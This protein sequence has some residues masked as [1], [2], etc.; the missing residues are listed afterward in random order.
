[1]AKQA[2]KKFEKV[3]MATIGVGGM[4]SGHVSRMKVIDEVEL[5]AVC[6]IDPDVAKAKGEEHG[7]PYYT[8][9]KECIRKSGAEAVTIATPHFQHPIVGVYALKQG[10]HVLSEKPMASTISAGEK[11]VKTAKQAKRLL[12]IMFQSRATP[13]VRAALDIVK[14]GKLGEIYRTC[15][16]A[17]GFRSMAYYNSAEWRATWVG[18]GGGVLVNQAPHP[19]DVFCALGGLPSKVLGRCDARIHDIEVEDEAEAL[20]TYKNGAHGYFYVS[21]DEAPGT[22]LT[23]ICGE[24][25]KLTLQSGKLTF[26][27]VKPG[28]KTY[29]YS[30][31]EMWAG[32]KTEVQE[33]ELQE[34]ETGHGA[35]IRN[36]AKAIR[37]VE[38]LIV[39]GECGL[40]S[41]ELANAIIMSSKLGKEV[42]LPISRSGY[43]KLMK[44][45][46]AGSKS[47]KGV[48]IIR[49]TDPAH[50][51]KKK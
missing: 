15:L 33:V 29:S 43:D 38:P 27:T 18:E 40:A 48:K 36:F 11:L 6:D 3:R 19:I 26:T 10:L 5:V 37:G 24:K 14:K 31:K 21:T 44:E 30:A 4:G 39:P 1:M 9:Y 45:L 23:E 2:R 7:V 17:S 32:P 50:V 8:D 46:Q 28:C 47:K 51:T 49:V 25:G 12:T 16:I 41:L 34:C 13:T 22:N 42:K 20:L 35:I